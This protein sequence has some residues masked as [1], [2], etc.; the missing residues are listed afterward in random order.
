MEIRSEHKRPN[1]LNRVTQFRGG[2]KSVEK[3]AE[4]LR[5]LV[6]LAE[7]RRAIQYG[8]LGKLIGAHQRVIGHILG[9]I[10]FALEEL[11]SKLPDI[12]P[13][14]ILVVNKKKGI[15]GFSGM[16]WLVP[17]KELREKLPLEAQRAI[18]EGAHQRIFKWD[19]WRE[20]LAAFGLQPLTLSE[21]PLEEALHVIET[22]TPHIGEG[23]DHRRL[24]E[25]VANNPTVIHLSQTIPHGKMEQIML[26]GDRMDV[27][28]EMPQ[29]WVCVEIKAK[30]S[31]EADILR[32]IFQCVKY[33]AVLEAQRHY[34][35][36]AKFP[37]VRVLLVL[38]N[39]LP[40]G[41]QRVK[42]F[43]GVEVISNIAV[44]DYFVASSG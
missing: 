14:Q 33:K 32:G 3:A 5:W 35:S 30:H 27:F 24:K 9:T 21:L 42:Q 29:E 6:K 40:K 1:H 10:G 37:D 13:I 39:E 11:K 26:S 12:P 34:L 16:S 43:L 41:L 15:P 8:E 28:F 7:A 31:G 44:P 22:A 4:T 38:A 25:Y 23:E 17:E 36:S 19:H 2:K 20:V 18:C